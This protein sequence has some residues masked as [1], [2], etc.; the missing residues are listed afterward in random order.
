M[1]S[2]LR[3]CSQ[4]RWRQQ[5]TVGAGCDETPPS[6]SV[7][8]RT[9]GQ[10]PPPLNRIGRPGRSGSSGSD[11]CRPPSYSPR[12]HA[13]TFV[14]L[15]VRSIAV[16]SSCNTPESAP[17]SCNCFNALTLWKQPVQQHRKPW[18]LERTRIYRPWTEGVDYPSRWQ[19]F[20]GRAA[21]QLCTRLGRSPHT[22]GPPHRRG[23]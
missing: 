23:W 22:R 4:Q 13:V 19:N 8:Q 18:P 6:A 15:R 20:A 12:A 3:G 16:C 7:A 1:T 14:A 11:A 5:R 2:R 9:V 17:P 10:S 21:W